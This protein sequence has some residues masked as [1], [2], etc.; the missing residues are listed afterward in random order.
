MP[1][2]PMP[3]D[4]PFAALSPEQIRGVLLRLRLYAQWKV[5]GNVSRAVELDP[6]NLALRAVEQTLDGS[7]AWNSQRFDLLKHLCNCVDSYV[8]HHFE[9]LARRP[10]VVSDEG[11]E[12]LAAPGAQGASPEELLEQDAEVA[13][14]GG[15]IRREHPRLVPLLNLVVEKGIS[16]ADRA[17]AARG[18]G[19]DPADP[20][21]MQR[22]YRAINALKKAV[23]RWQLGRKGAAP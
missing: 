3:E 6:E 11:L 21:Q 10:M 20:A 5:R 16:L 2:S 1:A 18:L 12:N 17:D 4:H 19:L 9:A 13:D 15:F 23:L 14:L 7:R 8:S 22:A